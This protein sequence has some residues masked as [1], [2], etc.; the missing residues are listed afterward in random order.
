M[1]GNGIYLFKNCDL[2][3]GTIEKGLKSGQ[4]KY[5]YNQGSCYEG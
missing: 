2:Y 4:G 1:Q 3:S 5:I